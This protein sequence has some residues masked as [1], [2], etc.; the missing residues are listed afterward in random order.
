MCYFIECL[1]RSSVMKFTTEVNID[2][3]HVLP[4]GRPPGKTTN[5][6]SLEGPQ[7]NRQGLTQSSIDVQPKGRCVWLLCIQ[8][9]LN[10]F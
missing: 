8:R 5:F 2:S 1:Y 3:N 10:Q 4:Y 9:R 7:F 6:I